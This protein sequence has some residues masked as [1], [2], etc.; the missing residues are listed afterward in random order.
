M[1]LRDSDIY[2]DYGNV[3]EMEEW[4]QVVNKSIDKELE[5]VFYQKM[6]LYTNKKYKKY[7]KIFSVKPKK[8]FRSE[9]SRQ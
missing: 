7:K 9:K 6:Q 2:I 5:E 1:R 4:I 8:A 3:K